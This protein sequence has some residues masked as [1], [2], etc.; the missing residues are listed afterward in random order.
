MSPKESDESEHNKVSLY[1]LASLSECWNTMGEMLNKSPKEYLKIEIRLYQGYIVFPLMR[2]KDDVVF[3]K[4]I[5][6]SKGESRRMIIKLA[7]IHVRAQ[8]LSEG[9]QR[10]N[11]WKWL[12]K[13][14]SAGTHTSN[15]VE[16]QDNAH[17]FSQE[18]L[19][20]S[21]MFLETLCWS[22]IVHMQLG[23]YFISVK[24]TAVW[25]SQDSKGELVMIPL[26]G[27]CFHSGEMQ[28]DSDAITW[29]L[30]QNLFR[31]VKTFDPQNLDH[32]YGP[33]P[34]HIPI[35]PEIGTILLSSIPEVWFYRVAER[36][37]SQRDLQ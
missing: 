4:K 25:R 26:W 11:E 20:I 17:C 19:P 22:S 3:L 1:C 32:C 27:L 10:E 13:L 23:D 7:N 37:Q 29:A 16:T 24:H 18:V 5:S 15:R 6:Q 12:L 2:V 8:Y 33:S 21:A 31:R 30:F 34:K 28:G 36:V 9:N 35:Y 14:C